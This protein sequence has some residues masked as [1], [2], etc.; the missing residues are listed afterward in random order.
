MVVIAV[1]RH[2]CEP[3]SC[4]FSVCDLSDDRFSPRLESKDCG[5]QCAD[6]RVVTIICS[7]TLVTTAA[8]TV[9][10]THERPLAPHTHTHS[11]IKGASAGPT[12]LQLIGR[13]LHHIMNMPKPLARICLFHFMSWWSWFYHT[14]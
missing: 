8:I 7:V 14:L 1:E 13:L 9:L 10:G 11:M 5:L 6:L 12:G 4:H 3:A 2:I